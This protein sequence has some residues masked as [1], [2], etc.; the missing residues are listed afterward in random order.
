MGGRDGLADPAT[1]GALRLLP[2]ARLRRHPVSWS[3]T[4]DP[5][6]LLADS[7]DQT[8]AANERVWNG[9]RGTAEGDHPCQPD[10]PPLGSHDRWTTAAVHRPSSLDCVVSR[11]YGAALLVSVSATAAWR[12]RLRRLSRLLGSVDPVG[13]LST[14]MNA[15]SYR[16]P[17]SSPAATA[18]MRANRPTGTAPETRLRSELHRQGYRFRKNLALRVGHTRTSPDIVFTRQRVAVYVDGCYWHSCPIH[19]TRPAANADYWLPK[20]ART[21]ERDREITAALEHEGW[22]VLRFWEHVSAEEAA[23]TVAQELI[24]LR[25]SQATRSRA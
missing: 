16:P 5:R 17:A 9:R 3:P 21:R 20:L 24:R 4:K 10:D 6:C 8:L 13:G 19:G 11:L 25:R 23:D 14:S 2:V 12:S 7:P 1:G 18:T 22:R 15:S